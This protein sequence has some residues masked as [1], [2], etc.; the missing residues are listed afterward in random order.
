VYL[1]PI[2]WACPIFAAEA[3]LG[4]YVFSDQLKQNDN[5]R[6]VVITFITSD[7]REF[8]ILPQ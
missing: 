2:A 6:G 4:S 7:I 1:S 3:V 5:G 8:G